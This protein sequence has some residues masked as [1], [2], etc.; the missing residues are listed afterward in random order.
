MVELIKG[1]LKKIGT[2]SHY[3]CALTE[4]GE[5]TKELLL[6]DFKNKVTFI[7]EKDLEQLEIQIHCSFYEYN[8]RT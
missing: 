4:I 7:K 6:R 5:D 3:N 2:F 8:E 1:N